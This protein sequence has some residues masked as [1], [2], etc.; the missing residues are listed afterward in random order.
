MIRRNIVESSY[1]EFVTSI[2]LTRKSKYWYLRSDETIVVLTLVRSP[3]GRQY[4]LAVGVVLRNLDAD[5][6][7]KAENASLQSRFDRLVPS[8][9][10]H[11]VN[12]LLDLRFPMDDVQ[13]REELLG[14]LRVHLV[15]LIAASSTL[16]GLRSAAG[17]PLV[18][19]SVV[20]EEALPLLA[21]PP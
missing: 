17:S 18:R 6:T 15:P 4:S 11:R 13:R 19:H 1:V 5:N 10:E 16:D 8:T 2:G 21:G 9:L 20:D 12:D 14:L 7:P 3:Y